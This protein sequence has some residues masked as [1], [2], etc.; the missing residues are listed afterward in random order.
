MVL[1][2]GI[3]TTS[4]D[5]RTFSLVNSTMNFLLLQ[6]VRLASHRPSVVSVV[7]RS[8][9]S[10]RRGDPCPDVVGSI[11][12]EDESR[13]PTR[14]PF[15]PVQ[16]GRVVTI[17]DENRDLKFCKVPL[18]SQGKVWTSGRRKEK[19]GLKG[20]L[21]VIDDLLRTFEKLC[22]CCQLGCF[23][24][25]SEIFT[26]TDPLNCVILL[27]HFTSRENDLTKLIF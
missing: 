27:S 26:F 25:F 20:D 22:P 16:D 6:S 12:N 10:G 11:P 8:D 17:R 19:S 4:P 3:R 13:N 7:E 1:P 24:L 23:S 15:S 5:R 21:R 2:G 18:L 9:R 14:P